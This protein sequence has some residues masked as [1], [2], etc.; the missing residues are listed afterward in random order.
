MSDSFRT[1]LSRIQEPEVTDENG[2]LNDK[3]NAAIGATF[4]VSS[5][6]T[7]M[8]DI[9]FRKKTEWVAKAER[10]VDA[11]NSQLPTETLLSDKYVADDGSAQMKHPDEQPAADGSRFSDVMMASLNTNEY[12][13]IAS[14]EFWTGCY[15][16]AQMAHFEMTSNEETGIAGQV[17]FAKDD[18]DNPNYISR[19]ERYA[20][21]LRVVAETKKP[22]KKL[23]AKR[24]KT[25]SNAK[26]Q[27]ALLQDQLAA[28]AS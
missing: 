3:V 17:G 19:E 7:T 13:A 20:P 18:K 26:H 9:I 5:K 27:N 14:A 25:L 10:A 22:T 1:L 2:V 21:K 24:Q 23:V 8:L 28:L 6:C 4:I 15:T 12:D 11:H 16:L